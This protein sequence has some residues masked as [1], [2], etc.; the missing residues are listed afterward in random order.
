LELPDFYLFSLQDF[1]S[2]D[3]SNGV[4]VKEGCQ[5]IL[6]YA[7][8]RFVCVTNINNADVFVA[9]DYTA[10]MLD[11]AVGAHC[12]VITHMF[13]KGR[14]Q[15]MCFNLVKLG[16]QKCLFTYQTASNVAFTKRE[17]C[18]IFMHFE[19]LRF[20][21][22][23]CINKNGT[24]ALYAGDEQT[25]ASLGCA[26]RALC[27]NITHLTKNNGEQQLRFEFGQGYKHTCLFTYETSC[28]PWLMNVLHPGKTML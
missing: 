11:C 27:G 14:F 22:M 19:N 6:H 1:A 17:G 25:A 7:D 24:I 10:K 8:M 9:D 28:L 15:N 4:F 5:D 18:D 16:Y 21:C 26:E 20:A 23:N 2:V 13:G 3:M 12:G